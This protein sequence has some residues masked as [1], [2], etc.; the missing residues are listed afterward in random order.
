M[1][2][3]MQIIKAESPEHLASLSKHCGWCTKSLH[4]ANNYLSHGQAWAFQKEGKRRPSYLMFVSETGSWEF[5]SKGNQHVQPNAFI[6]DYSELSEFV[7]TTLPENAF[8]EIKLNTF[9]THMTAESDG[10]F[11]FTSSDGT[12]TNICMPPPELN[13]FSHDG[14]LE[15]SQS[16]A[17]ECID[18]IPSP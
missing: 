9:V 11:T 5:K 15:I 13:V 3:M 6:D 7:K 8:N 14:I 10:T 4:W 1:N 17:I 18:S 2:R 16:A 12:Q